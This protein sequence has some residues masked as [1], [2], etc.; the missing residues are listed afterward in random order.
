MSK[1]EITVPESW[2]DLSK[3]YSDKIIK[4]AKISDELSVEEI[5]ISILDLMR[6]GYL[7]SELDFKFFEMIKENISSELSVEID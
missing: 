3:T 4:L 7:S 1:F 6:N 2:Q 5:C